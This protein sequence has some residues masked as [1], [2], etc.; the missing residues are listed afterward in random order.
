M[1]AFPHAES[2]CHLVCDAEKTLWTGRL[3]D[4]AVV[5]IEVDIWSEGFEAKTHHFILNFSDVIYRLTIG[6]DE[7]FPFLL[8]RELCDGG[9]CCWR[10]K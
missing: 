1:S 3:I 9:R 2:R 6:G 8:R 4:A 10:S 5:I 7:V